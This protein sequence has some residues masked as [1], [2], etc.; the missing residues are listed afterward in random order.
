MK[1]L[2]ANIFIGGWDKYFTLIFYSFANFHV[3]FI[4][5]EFYLFHFLFWSLPYFTFTGE[6]VTSFIVCHDMQK[7]IS[8]TARRKLFICNLIFIFYFQQASAQLSDKMLR[9]MKF[10]L[11]THFIQKQQPEVFCKKKSFPVN[12]AKPLRTTFLQNTSGD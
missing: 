1:I 8:A 10:L 9:F 2:G 3:F 11:V 6:I 12:F 5:N 4:C 7:Y